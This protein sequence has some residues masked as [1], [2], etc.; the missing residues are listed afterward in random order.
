M[1]ESIC[2]S[3]GFA[4]LASNA[5]ADMI[6]PGWQYPHCGTC[7]AIH[8]FCTGCELSADSPSMVVIFFDPTAETAVWHER[9]AW[10]S[11][12]TVQAP[13]S[14]IPQPYLVPV[15]L[16]LSRKTHN[17]GVSGATSTSCGLLLISN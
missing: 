17:S 16:S 11:R 4:V 3:L 2:S 13:H 14:P 9:T 6:C 7:S 1:A 8:A 15:M 12:C 10:P 5:A